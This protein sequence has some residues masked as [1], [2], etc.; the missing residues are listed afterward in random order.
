MRCPVGKISFY[1]VY[2]TKS[3]SR[4]KSRFGSVSRTK[5]LLKINFQ[6]EPLSSQWIVGT[7]VALG[8]RLQQ[9]LIELS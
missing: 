2:E 1:S 9:I 8:G 6:Y 7:T 3:C 5:S 4:T